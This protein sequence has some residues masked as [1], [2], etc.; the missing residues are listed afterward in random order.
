MKAQKKIENFRNREARASICSVD[1]EAAL[2]LS[3]NQAAARMHGLMFERVSRDSVCKI[4]F[5]TTMEQLSFS[6]VL[7]EQLI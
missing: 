1:F 6:A 4:D 3:T 7:L 5:K 2:Q